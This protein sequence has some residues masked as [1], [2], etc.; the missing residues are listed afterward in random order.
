MNTQVSGAYTTPVAW[1]TTV[2]STKPGCAISDAG[3]VAFNWLKGYEL[4]PK[5]VGRTEPFHRTAQVDVGAGIPEPLSATLKVNAGPPAGTELG[6]TVNV[7][8]VCPLKAEHMQ[9]TIKNRAKNM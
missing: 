2:I 9:A 3:I 7:S 6:V 5:V 4:L 8:P 1:S